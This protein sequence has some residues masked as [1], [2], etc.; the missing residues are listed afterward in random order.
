M[1]KFLYTLMLFPLCCLSDVMIQED[2]KI[3]GKNYLAENVSIR[4]ADG[5][6]IH[7]LEAGCKIPCIEK[8]VLYT[9]K[10]WQEKITLSLYN[11][12]SELEGESNFIGDFSVV[13]IPHE[14]RAGS[15]I[16]V[17]FKASEK[18]VW[19]SLAKDNEN[20]E[21]IKELPL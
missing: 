8:R 7:A 10:D 3:T 9:Y 19:I 13:K 5:G 2:V 20:M 12:G 17:Y 6:F 21:L 14:V 1:S 4:L 15:K 16:E 11:I 18:G